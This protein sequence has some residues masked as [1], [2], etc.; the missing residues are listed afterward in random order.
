MPV[1]IWWGRGRGPMQ[2]RYRWRPL[3]NPDNIEC[4]LSERMLTDCRIIHSISIDGECILKI[5]NGILTKAGYIDKRN[6]LEFCAE[7]VRID[8]RL[9]PTVGSKFINIEFRYDP[10]FIAVIILVSSGLLRKSIEFLAN[11]L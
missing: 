7:F 3:T 4:V 1:S 11:L 6:I 2:H 5:E 8:S 9:S 10:K